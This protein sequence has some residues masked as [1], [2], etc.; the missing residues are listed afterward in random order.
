MDGRVE[1]VDMEDGTR[2]S[3]LTVRTENKVA[4]KV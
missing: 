3:W 2:D 1:G 4:E